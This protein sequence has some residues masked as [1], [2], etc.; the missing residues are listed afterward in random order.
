M[1]WTSDKLRRILL[2]SAYLKLKN[3]CSHVVF[4]IIAVTLMRTDTSRAVMQHPCGSDMHRL[5][6]N[7]LVKKLKSVTMPGVFPSI[8]IT[9]GLANR[10]QHLL[11]RH[12]RGMLFMEVRSTWKV[13]LMAD[14][15]TRVSCTDLILQVKV[16]Y[17][18]NGPG[19]VFS[20]RTLLSCLITCN[21][22]W[23]QGNM[24]VILVY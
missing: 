17:V 24:F 8:L 12:F 6:A 19:W 2:I 23:A 13:T 18:R 16:K 5:D 22:L 15:L 3:L 14:G 10:G 7:C 11:W 20:I 1:T 4:A 9:H 21:R